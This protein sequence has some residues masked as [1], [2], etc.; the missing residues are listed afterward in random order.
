MGEPWTGNN[1]TQVCPSTSV[2]NR[3]MQVLASIQLLHTPVCSASYKYMMTGSLSHSLGAVSM[4]DPVAL[5]LMHLAPQIVC[6]E[7]H[8]DLC[9]LH[10]LIRQP[11]SFKLEL[12]PICYSTF[13]AN[14][15]LHQ[16][17]VSKGAG[18]GV[19]QTSQSLGHMSVHLP[20]T[21][22]LQAHSLT[23]TL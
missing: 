13:E 5:Q 22:W 16:K 19:L 3:E 2:L 4:P 15:L 6:N 12:T 7:F 1:R 11:I 21:D 17:F 23:P 20:S 9:K 8:A 18:E 10:S 14:K